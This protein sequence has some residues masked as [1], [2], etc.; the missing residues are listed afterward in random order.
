VW[1]T[2]QKLDA[3]NGSRRSEATS[4]TAES[5]TAGT[6]LA[7]FEVEKPRK[8]Y[9]KKLHKGARAS[10]AHREAELLAIASLTDSSSKQQAQAVHNHSA[11]ATESAE[12]EQ[13]ESSGS[14]SPFDS[15]SQS[16]LVDAE[17]TGGRGS[18]SKGRRKTREGSCMDL[19]I[20]SGG[21]RRRQG[22]SHHR[23][24]EEVTGVRA[25]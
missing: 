13:Q 22:A 4:T 2:G 14:A 20:R 24:H 6:T 15:R 23:T 1:G 7:A 10:S 9:E 21:E 3:T 19:V 25:Q 12:K 17:A 11:A 5:V 8:G 16:R 18:M